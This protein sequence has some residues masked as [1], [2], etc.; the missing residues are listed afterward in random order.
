MV[1]KEPSHTEPAAHVMSV[2]LNWQLRRSQFPF[3][4]APDPRLTP[5]HPRGLIPSQ[6]HLEIPE[7]SV[8]S[9]G[10]V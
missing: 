4:S 9:L 6:A 2:N 10:G 8:F 5:L 7:N 1:V 3:T